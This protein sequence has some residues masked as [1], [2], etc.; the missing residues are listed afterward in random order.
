M[1]NDYNLLINA[2]VGAITALVTFIQTRKKY[3]K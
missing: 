2:I 3:R 1:E